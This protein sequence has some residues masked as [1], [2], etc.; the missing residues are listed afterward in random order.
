MATLDGGCG[1]R[2]RETVPQGW[3][4]GEVRRRARFQVEAGDWFHLER[5]R[6]RVLV[7]GAAAPSFFFFF[8]AFGSWMKPASSNLG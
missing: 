2:D 5:T 7:G 1:N 3:M 8:V 4:V 6:P